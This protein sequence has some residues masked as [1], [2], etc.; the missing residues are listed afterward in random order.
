M[1]KKTAKNQKKPIKATPT[2][3]DM[4]I[5]IYDP[6]HEIARRDGSVLLGVVV[7]EIAQ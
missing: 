4:R 1:K 2:P 5:K 3:A 6:P 7:A